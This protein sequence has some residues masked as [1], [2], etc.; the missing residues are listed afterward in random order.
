MLNHFQAN[1]M[2]KYLF[3]TLLPGLFS[4]A[5]ESKKSDKVNIDEVYQHYT[6]SSSE[7]SSN[8]TSRAQF[9]TGAQWDRLETEKSGGV[10]VELTGSSQVTLNGQPMQ[11]DHGVMDGT[12]YTGSSAGNQITWVWTDNNGKTYTNSATMEPISFGVAPRF[13][14]SANDLTISW[15]GAPVR[16][17][18]KVRIAMNAK[19]TD[20]NNKTKDKRI[21][22]E[23]GERGATSLTFTY[24]LLSEIA[25][26]NVTMEISRISHIPLKEATKEG[27]F[28]DLTFSGNDVSTSFSQQNNSLF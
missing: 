15:K 26:Q 21:S 27:G 17:N 28:I 23:T 13:L 7:G 4:C 19:I 16:E 8:F 5:E 12:Y 6:A 3:I 2:K 18:E 22:K 25:G 24:T 10:T 11:K 1:L 14:N 9:Q 20:S